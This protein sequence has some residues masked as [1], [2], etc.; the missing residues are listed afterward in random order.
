MK[1]NYTFPAIFDYEEEGFINIEF[2]DFPGAMTCVS[3]EEDA[4]SEAQDL[5]ALTIPAWLD[6]LAKA[7]N[8]NFSAVLVQGLKEA[9][10]LKE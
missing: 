5:L 8:I 9:L 10:E 3:E 6:V 4:I 1:D 2:C 7:N